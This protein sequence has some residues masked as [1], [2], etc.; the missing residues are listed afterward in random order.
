MSAKNEIRA[1]LEK[2]FDALHEGDVDKVRAIFHPAAHLYS[3]TGG[4]LVDM[5]LDDYVGLIAG[6]ASPASHG[7]T[8][9]GTVELIDESGPE[10]AL[11]RVTLDIGA[12]RFTDY[13]T[14]LKV[15]GRWRI[16]CKTYHFVERDA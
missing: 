14:L 13:L 5:P 3:G 4:A 1:A 11:A 2:Y 10:S 12:R 7:V 9:S 8:R 16:I 15:D 6:R